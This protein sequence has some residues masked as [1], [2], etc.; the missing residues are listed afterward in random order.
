MNKS[1]KVSETG[2]FK[3]SRYHTQKQNFGK[4]FKENQSMENKK[5]DIQVNE[6][7]KSLQ[8]K[9]GTFSIHLLSAVIDEIKSLTKNGHIELK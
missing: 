4:L 5:V 3:S 7:A 9:S 1:T 2:Q 6:E 8:Q